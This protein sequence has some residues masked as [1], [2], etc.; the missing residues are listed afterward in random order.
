[1]LR[2]EKKRHRPLLS[3]FR[4]SS[5]P[6]EN[7]EER[8]LLADWSYK[9][10]VLSPCW[11][12]KSRLHLLLRLLHLDM[13]VHRIDN[14][15]KVGQSLKIAVLGLE[16]FEENSRPWKVSWVAC[17]GCTIF[18]E[19]WARLRRETNEAFKIVALLQIEMY[20][21]RSQCWRAEGSSRPVIVWRRQR[22]SR[23]GV[24]RAC[25]NESKL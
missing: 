23:H 19:W 8:S 4:M 13:L 7:F 20:A 6:V 15:R 11:V 21:R 16:E 1:M 14:L 10:L 2:N 18:S 5:M 3:P 9:R 17:S 22:T 12:N 25:L 24:G